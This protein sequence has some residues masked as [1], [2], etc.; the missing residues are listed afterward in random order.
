[1]ETD[2]Q[3]VIKLNNVCYAKVTTSPIK[4]YGSM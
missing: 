4:T 1:M 2:L 3:N